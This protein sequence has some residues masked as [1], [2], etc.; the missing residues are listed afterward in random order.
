MVGEGERR[1]WNEARARALAARGLPRSLELFKADLR[2]RL[3]RSRSVVVAGVIVD[4]EVVIDRGLIRALK[5]Q[6]WLLEVVIAEGDLPR[7]DPFDIAEP[8]DVLILH[9]GPEGRSKRDR[10][11]PCDR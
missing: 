10:R 11:V 8:R 3:S 5:E 1:S 7:P 2:Q 9:K 4:L 6:A